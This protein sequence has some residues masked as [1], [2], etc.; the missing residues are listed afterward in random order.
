VELP[1][2]D[3]QRDRPGSAHARPVQ[4]AARA[5]RR[6]EVGLRPARSREPG[7]CPQPHACAPA[8][9]AR[10]RRPRGSCPVVCRPHARA[11]QPNPPPRREGKQVGRSSRSRPGPLPGRVTTKLHLVRESRGCPSRCSPARAGA[12]SRPSW[13]RRLGQCACCGP[14]GANARAA[15]Q[16]RGV[17]LPHG[18]RLPGQQG[19][20]W[21]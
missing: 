9:E 16:R 12:T 8:T 1:A 5:P 10:R 13:N 6:V 18:V 3:S 7:W 20:S 19:A 15:W 2:E 17:Q 14:A 11:R 4:G 21:P